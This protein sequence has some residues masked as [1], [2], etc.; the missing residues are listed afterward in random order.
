MELLRELFEYFNDPTHRGYTEYL[1]DRGYFKSPVLK[2]K[3]GYV[4]KNYHPEENEKS[5]STLSAAREA[6]PTEREHHWQI[7]DVDS[8][9]V[10]SEPDW[11]EGDAYRDWA[12]KPGY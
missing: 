3:K 6:A 8:K 10:V 12:H 4:L 2:G 9:K 5:F 7:F 11:V 1:K